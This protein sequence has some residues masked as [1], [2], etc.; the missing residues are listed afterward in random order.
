MRCEQCRHMKYL[1]EKAVINAVLAGNGEVKL[2]E[3][4]L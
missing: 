3:E 2:V 1:P 4:M